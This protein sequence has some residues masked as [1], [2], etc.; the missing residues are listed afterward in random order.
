MLL[1]LSDVHLAQGSYIEA[2]DGPVLSRYW[3]RIAELGPP[4]LL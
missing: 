1:A 2:C 3:P 4:N